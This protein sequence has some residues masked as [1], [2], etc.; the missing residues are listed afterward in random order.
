MILYELSSFM[1][2]SHRSASILP[3][4]KLYFDVIK[5]TEELSKHNARR[6][7]NLPLGVNIR[8]ILSHPQHVYWLV[9]SCV[10]KIIEIAARPVPLIGCN[11]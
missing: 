5:A 10:Q 6:K 8:K 1:V 9:C 4:S 11:S 3:S 2:L 7:Y